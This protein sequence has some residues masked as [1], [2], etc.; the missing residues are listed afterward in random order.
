MFNYKINTNVPHVQSLVAA[1]VLVALMFG[2]IL[3]L[4]AKVKG[5]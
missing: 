5:F 2:P 3:V 1:T 4:A